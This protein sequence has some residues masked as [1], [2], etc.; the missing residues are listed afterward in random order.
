MMTERLYRRSLKGWG[1]Q[2]PQDVPPSVTAKGLL[3]QQCTSGSDVDNAACLRPSGGR[4]MRECL[5]H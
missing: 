5:S 2:D 3:P 4:N 1:R